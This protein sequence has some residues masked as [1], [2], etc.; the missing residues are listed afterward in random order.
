[1]L[2]FDGKQLENGG[3]LASYKILQDSTIDIILNLRGGGADA[4]LM[5]RKLDAWFLDPKYD[6]DFSK[7]AA[8]PGCGEVQARWG[9]VHQTDWLDEICHQAG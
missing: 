9:G 2:C 5:L 6:Y 4:N 1:M 3:S 8:R 7:L